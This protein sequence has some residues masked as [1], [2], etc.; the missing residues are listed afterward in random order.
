M[1]AHV[2][3]GGRVPDHHGFATN[4]S[5]RILS[6]DVAWITFRGAI[7]TKAYPNKNFCEPNPPFYPSSNGSTRYAVLLVPLF[8]VTT[9]CSLLDT[10]DKERGSSQRH[11]QNSALGWEFGNDW[12]V[13]DS[14][15]PDCA[16]V[17]KLRRTG[18]CVERMGLDAS[19]QNTHPIFFAICKCRWSPSS[20]AVS[21]GRVDR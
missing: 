1:L 17:A 11:H 18:S 15:S 9:N 14:H 2:A 16:S 10:V 13:C 12:V 5:Q 20:C 6:S 19:T 4:L 3:G 8:R 7:R 21:T